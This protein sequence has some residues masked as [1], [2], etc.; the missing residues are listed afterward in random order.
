M[1]EKRAWTERM[2]ASLQKRKKRI[3]DIIQIGNTSDLPSRAFDYILAAA[4]LLNIAAMFCDTFSSMQPYRYI[5]RI[6]EHLEKIAPDEDGLVWP[7][8]K[9]PLETN[10]K[11]RDLM[12][13]DIH[14]TKEDLE[15]DD[16][17]AYI[18]SKG[19]ER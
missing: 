3:F 11:W 2:A 18:L 15:K 19:Q 5:L 13:T 10:S 7:K 12:M 4:I 16:R 1:E 14:F 17:L 6:E 8:I 9:F